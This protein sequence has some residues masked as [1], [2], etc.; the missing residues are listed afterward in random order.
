[1]VR[2][3]NC[4]SDA[5]GFCLCDLAAS[6]LCS[7][8]YSEH[9]QSSSFVHI[10]LP[11]DLDPSVISSA[12]VGDYIERNRK[13]AMLRANMEKHS[14]LLN[15]QLERHLQDLSRIEEELREAIKLKIQTLKD[16]ACELIRKEVGAIS[17]LAREV[18]AD[19]KRPPEAAVSLPAEMILKCENI[20][21]FANIQSSE[22]RTA[23]SPILQTI[24]EM[25]GAI[26]SPLSTQIKERLA[27]SCLYWLQPGNK[28]LT[29]LDP[30]RDIANV[31]EVAGATIFL[32]GSGICQIDEQLFVVGGTWSSAAGLI[33]MKTK[34]YT[35][36]KPMKNIRGYHGMI[37]YKTIA[38]AFGGAHQQGIYKNYEMYNVENTTWTVGN[39]PRE[40]KDVRVVR[41]RD[42][43]YLTDYTSNLIETFTPAS[44]A[45]KTL[46]CVLPCSNA[47]SV[48]I[49]EA[50]YLVVFKGNNMITCKVL[51]DDSVEE[52]ARTTCDESTWQVWQ[53]PIQIGKS[54]YF[55]NYTG[56][57][58]YAVDVKPLGAIVSTKVNYQVT[59]I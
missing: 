52:V 51:A 8:C 53:T 34:I 4:N 3:S 37:K 48:L 46:S 13:A 59:K 42:K 40:L 6:A 24:E 29:V 12:R 27:F 5:L 10:L 54:Y 11:L 57:R 49:Y 39:L 9:S 43:M 19:A 28:L 26:L 32:E 35:A 25:Q 7:V 55:F 1:M 41:V 31:K 14:T 22:L 17:Q 47:Y 2:C 38:Y 23:T 44:N 45:F 33:D 30:L 21:L 18:G 15:M 16:Q 56:R 58:V 36:L 20:D 50:D